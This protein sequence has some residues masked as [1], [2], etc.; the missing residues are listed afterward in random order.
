M[1]RLGVIVLIILVS[2][3]ILLRVVR[4][5]VGH[6]LAQPV[7]QPSLAASPTVVIDPLKQTSTS[8]FVPTWTLDTISGN[9]DKYI[10]FGVAPTEDG[11]DT[12]DT[13]TQNI[14]L[15]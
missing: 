4:A 2:A 3:F 14:Q 10:Y 9:Y 7:P 1:R 12:S 6:D 13:A 8:L 5:K 11:I 15:F